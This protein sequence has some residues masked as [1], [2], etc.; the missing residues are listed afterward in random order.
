MYAHTYTYMQALAAILVLLNSRCACSNQQEGSMLFLS[1]LEAKF[2][3]G[4][5]KGEVTA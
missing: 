4:Q 1:T 5:G 3:A 2:I